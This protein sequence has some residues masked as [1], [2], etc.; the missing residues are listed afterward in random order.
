VEL[1]ASIAHEVN[2]P[3]SG[4]INSANAGV[5]WL[6]SQPPDVQRARHSIDRIIRDAGRASEVVARVRDLAKK[7]P[8]RKS[9]L[10]INETVGEII[11][12]TRQEVRKNHVRLKTQLSADVPLILAD[13]IQLQQVILNLMIN[14]V[15]ALTAVPDAERVLQITTTA[16]S[17]GDVGLTVGDSGPAGPGETR[18]DLR[19]FL[20]DQA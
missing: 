18:R 14:A 15:E 17:S 8:P 19:R 1:T 7:T 5:R 9:W 11:S 4:V 12:L 6:D 13:R 2:Q 3:L 10:N 16:G 20:H